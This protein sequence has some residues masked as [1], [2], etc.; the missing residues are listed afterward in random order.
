MAVNFK[1]LFAIPIVVILSCATVSN[2][3][4]SQDSEDSRTLSKKERKRKERVKK[5]YDN[6][7]YTEVIKEIKKNDE[8]DLEDKIKLANAYRLNHNGSNAA[9]WYAEV[10]RVSKD[11]IH[12]LRYAQ[13]LHT[14]GQEPQSKQQYEK[15]LEL[16]Q[17]DDRWSGIATNLNQNLLVT[18]RFKNHEVKLKN[19]SVINTDK[20][21]FSPTILNDGVLFVSTK[22]PKKFPSYDEDPWIGEN[23]MSLFWAPLDEEKNELKEATI[24][25]YD[26]T[27]NYH[28]GPASFSKDGSEIFFT[29]N[30]LVKGKRKNNKEGIMRLQVYMAQQVKDKWSDAVSLAFNTDEF[31]ECHPSLSSDGNTLYFASDRA[32]GYGGMDLYKVVRKDDTW[33]EPMNLGGS[34]NT[35]E[36]EV[37][38]FIHD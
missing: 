14:L 24:F 18:D 7:E 16:V 1:L 21:E 8:L 13:V 25:S 26:I 35:A 23:F 30:H 31:E 32:G 22:K 27:S 3:Q 36:N 15:Y 29:R 12:H 5:L 28:E 2:A 38:P 37:F 11:P 9:M 10:T 19:E 33:S 4:T 6:F 34:I 17:S 20:L